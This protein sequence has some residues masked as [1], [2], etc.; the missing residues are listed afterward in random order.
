M[1]FK[2]II[3]AGFPG[4]GKT[5]ASKDDLS[6]ADSDSSSWSKDSS[7][8]PDNYL[9]HIERVYEEAAMRFVLTS[10][11]REVIEGLVSRRIPFHV[12]VPTRELK[13]VY[14]ERYRQRGSPP[15][16]IKLMDDKWGSFIDDI[17]AFAYPRDGDRPGLL[18]SVFYLTT[19]DAYVSDVM[20][21]I[22]SRGLRGAGGAG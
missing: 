6:I 2:T 17:E 3:V 5:A 4:V 20:G 7:V 11:H 22:R 19:P 18:L 10:T 14:L 12:V 1:S 8:W 21:V 16:F 9:D 15:E 13:T